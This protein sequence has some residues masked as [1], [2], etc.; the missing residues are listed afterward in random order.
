MERE[1]LS[2]RCKGRRPS[3]KNRKGQSTDAE[4][5]DGAAR[6]R[7]EGPVMGLDGIV[8]VICT[9]SVVLGGPYLYT[10]N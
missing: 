2:F 8:R 5:R 4:H 6:S 3:G 7:V 1:N 9:T 10:A